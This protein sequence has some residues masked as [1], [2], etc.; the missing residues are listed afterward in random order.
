MGLGMN[1]LER[2]EAKVDT[3]NEVDCWE[4][5]AA[6]RNGYGVFGV[7]AGKV[8]YAHRF[9]WEIYVGPIPEGMQLDHL[10]RN[11]KCVNP[12]HLEPVTQRENLIRGNGWASKA[13]QKTCIRGHNDWTIRK[14]GTR[15]CRSC[16]RERDAVR[17]HDRRKKVV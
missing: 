14:N 8:V 10:C 4:W 7:R 6:L 3:P 2:F 17:V 12:D 11:R 16:L 13:R 5:T 15:A 9:M 1:V